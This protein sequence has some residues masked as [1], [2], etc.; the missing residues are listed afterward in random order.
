M[1]AFDRKRYNNSEGT[2][3]PTVLVALAAKAF[4]CELAFL[5]SAGKAT[6]AASVWMRAVQAMGEVQ[7]SECE[8]YKLFYEYQRCERSN[9]FDVRGAC[10]SKGACKVIL[11]DIV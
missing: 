2:G 1:Q 5:E 8:W 3:I 10:F 6:D 7:A 9:R 4:E 11:S